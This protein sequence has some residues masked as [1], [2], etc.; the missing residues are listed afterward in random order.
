MRDST[1]LTEIDPRG[2]ATITLNRPEVN[3][4]YNSFMIQEL[5]S[6]VQELME[7]ELI[8]IIVLRG[9]GRHFQAGADLN[10]INKV[11]NLTRAENI[12][13]SQNTTDT[14]R[15]LNQCLKPTF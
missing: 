4:A 15:F 3:N 11:S 14:V 12:T 6:A 8:R 10:W 1:V 7:N 13:V 5:L 9:N 2:V